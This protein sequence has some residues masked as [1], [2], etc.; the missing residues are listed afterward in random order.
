MRVSR[1]WVAVSALVV[2]AAAV[3]WIGVQ[4][5]GEQSAVEGPIQPRCSQPATADAAGLVPLGPLA[6]T[7]LTAGREARL[8]LDRGQTRTVVMRQDRGSRE[9]AL[10]MTA[11]DGSGA[12]RLLA[13]G[14]D[15]AISLPSRFP[16]SAG[17]D[18]TPLRGQHRRYVVVVL[19]AHPGRWRI[20]VDAAGQRLGSVVVEL[21]ASN[22]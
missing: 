19:A 1:R 11:C 13:I 8:E 15:V 2:A 17:A 5:L 10:R 22:R 9:L 21:V 4:A 14:A 12:A 16:G 6:L 20:S 18:E 3:A 7:G